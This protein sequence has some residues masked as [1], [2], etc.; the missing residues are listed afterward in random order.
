MRGWTI[1]RSKR[2]ETTDKFDLCICSNYLWVGPSNGFRRQFI[3]SKRALYVVASLSSSPPPSSVRPSPYFDYSSVSLTLSVS[4]S[5][6]LTPP[7]Y[8]SLAKLCRQTFRCRVREASPRRYVPAHTRAAQFLHVPHRSSSYKA[9]RVVSGSRG[10]STVV[11]ST[12]VSDR[13]GETLVSVEWAIRS[14]RG[15]RTRVDGPVFFWEVN[16]RWM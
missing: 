16:H 13:P 11:P 6:S 1:W 15:Q 12:Y 5:L 4:L 3:I 14:D 2:G 9:N 7:P 8:T 10:R